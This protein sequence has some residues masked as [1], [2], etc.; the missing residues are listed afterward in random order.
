[1]AG[2]ALL[3]LAA[4]I[5]TFVEPCQIETEFFIGLPRCGMTSP[6]YQNSVWL[7]IAEAWT[8]ANTA[9]DILM[10]GVAVMV[11]V[12]M[13]LA[14]RNKISAALLCAL[15]S[16][17]CVASCV[18]LVFLVVNIHNYSYLGQSILEAIWS[19]IEPGLGIIAASLATLRPLA[20][21]V[22]GTSHSEQ[23][24]AI[25]NP[26]MMTTTNTHLQTSQALTVPKGIKF[27]TTKFMT[28]LSVA[29]EGRTGEPELRHHTLTMDV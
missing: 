18:R 14:R 21:A 28:T 16:I 24:S 23:S 15:G 11:I 6:F 5:F 8:L 3:G 19:S 10:A 12:Q 20:R 2:P 26:N 9:S 7:R 25:S 17:G 27:M 22:F 1:M 29:E 13:Q 4:I